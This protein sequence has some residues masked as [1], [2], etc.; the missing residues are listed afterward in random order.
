LKAELLEH[1][2]NGTTVAPVSEGCHVD[3]AD[4][5]QLKMPTQL[6]GKVTYKYKTI[7][8]FK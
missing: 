2:L 8:N 1:T 3:I 6:A 5:K 7:N 4:K